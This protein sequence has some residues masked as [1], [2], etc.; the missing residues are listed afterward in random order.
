M[1]DRGYGIN[2]LRYWWNATP[3]A[4]LHFTSFQDAIA[5]Y[6]AQ[7]PDFIAKLGKMAQD[8]KTPFDR[9]KSALEDLAKQQGDKYPHY[10]AI[11]Q[12]IV[13]ASGQVTAGD[14]AGAAADGVLQAG[15]YLA[16]GLGTYA[17]VAVVVGVIILAPE[18][19]LILRKVKV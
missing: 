19:K 2:V 15:K 6:D 7:N 9:I 4:V 16:F 17:L 10:S 18:L 5:Y 14:I 11:L 1:S 8:S 12:A 13:T 3:M